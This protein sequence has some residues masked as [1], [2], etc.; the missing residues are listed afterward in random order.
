[1][2]VTS[3]RSLLRSIEIRGGRAARAGGPPTTTE[4]AT[5]LFTVPSRP[6]PLGVVLSFS[7]FRPGVAGR[8][9]FPAPPPPLRPLGLDPGVFRRAETGRLPFRC[10]TA[11]GLELTLEVS[12]RASGHVPQAQT[13]LRSC[14]HDLAPVEFLAPPTLPAHT[15]HF[16]TPGLDGKTRRPC[17][18]APTPRRE[19]PTPA[20]VRL[21]RFSRP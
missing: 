9:G 17:P 11:H 14:I 8:L 2:L 7:V 6:H 3:P 20:S 21:R 18:R 16:P 5:D 19:L 4:I 15:I 12:H 13:R 1:L 10:G